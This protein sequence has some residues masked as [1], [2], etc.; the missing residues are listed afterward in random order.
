MKHFMFKEITPALRALCSEKV[1]SECIGKTSTEDTVMVTTKDGVIY[2][3]D[4]YW[5]LDLK[6]EVNSGGLDELMGEI[7]VH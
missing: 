3:I 4:W 1:L 5:E 6:D 7:N 2:D